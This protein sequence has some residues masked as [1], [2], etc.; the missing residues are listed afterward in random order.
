M[1]TRLKDIAV[2]LNLSV[3]TVSAAIQ[4]REE[5]SPATRERV[6][7]TVAELGYRPNSLARG[8]VTRR[9]QIIGVIVPDLSRSFFTEVL[10]EIDHA[11]IQRKSDSRPKSILIEP[12]LI[13]RQSTDRGILNVSE[14]AV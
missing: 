2:L 9:T 8:L 1:A 3:S 4:S 11:L 5:I 6:L 14:S 13:V 7:K 12:K 10:K